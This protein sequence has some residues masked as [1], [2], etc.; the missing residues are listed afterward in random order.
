[1]AM[2]AV[3]KALWYIEHHFERPV[4]LDELAA[5]VGLSRFHLSRSFALTTGRSFSQHLRGRRL[6]EAARALAAGAPDILAVALAAGYGSH[7]AFSRAF[8][9]QFGLTPDAARARA[10]LA[11]LKL[12]EPILMP[13][14]VPDTIETPEIRP[15]DSILLAGLRR[16][17]RYED[18]GGIPLLWQRFGPFIDTIPG[19]LRTLDAYGVCFKSEDERD[20]GFDYLA[21]VPVRSL[22]E[23]P[24]GLVGVRIPALSFAV[25]QHRGHV[26]AMGGTCGAAFEWMA[27]N[28]RAY[29][30]SSVTMVEYY[31]PTFD[32]RTGLGGCEVW[33]PVRD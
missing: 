27:Q 17:F 4:T 19:Q 26:S 12:V 24:D 14:T 18:R 16:F 32:P 25:F 2:D 21:A 7:E 31:P 11:D 23:L 30:D 29:P 5:L 13:D 6:S 8:R 33:I 15:V 20:D 1:M 10:S 22:D 3:R 28:Q 9:D